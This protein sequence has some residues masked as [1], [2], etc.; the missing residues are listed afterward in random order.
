MNACVTGGMV[1]AVPVNADVIWFLFHFHLSGRIAFE[2]LFLVRNIK[3]MAN[4]PKTAPI[5]AQNFVFTPLLS[6]I[7]QRRNAHAM[8]I[9]EMMIILVIL[10]LLNFSYNFRSSDITESLG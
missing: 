6:A 1:I 4:G 5:I 10:F 2:A 8:H 9:I 7:F 3:G